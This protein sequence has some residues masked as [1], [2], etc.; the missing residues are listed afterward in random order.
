[1][2]TIFWRVMVWLDD[3]VNHPVWDFLSPADNSGMF[4]DKLFYDFCQWSQIGN[5]EN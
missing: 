1:M 5:F 2:I 3:H 4:L